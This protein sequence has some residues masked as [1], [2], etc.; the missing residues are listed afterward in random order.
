MPDQ[1]VFNMAAVVVPVVVM[2]AKCAPNDTTAIEGTNFLH[3]MALLN[4]LLWIAFK[5]RERERERD[6]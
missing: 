1:F 4:S 3:Q 5:T 6:P 2:P